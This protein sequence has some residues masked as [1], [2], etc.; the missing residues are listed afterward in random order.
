MSFHWYV[1][2][3]QVPGRSIALSVITALTL[4]I[5]ITAQAAPPQLNTQAPGYYR[6]ALGEFEITAL[7]D[8]SINI[9]PMLL[10]G[11]SEEDLQAL[12]ARMFA[13][14]NDG[15]QTAVNG[16]LV[17]TGSNLVLVDTGAAACFG[18]SLGR[19]HDNIRAA[20][21]ELKQVDTVLLTHLHA[22]HAC[23]LLDAEGNAAFSNAEVRV[24]EDEAGFWLSE[25][26]AAKAPKAMQSFFKM[27]R[28]S[29]AP[30][31]ENNRLK[32]YKIGDEL[33]PG[34]ETVSTP[35][36]TPGHVSYLFSSNDESLLIWGDIVHN[37]AVQFVYPEVSIEYDIDS[38]QA[39][40]TRKRIFAEAAL[41]KL[42]VAGAHL[43]FPGLGHVRAERQGY[44]WVPAEYRPLAPSN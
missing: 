42:W 19:M 17:H 1:L 15:I 44:L 40:A 8:G 13:D 41:D 3:R 39:I 18:P 26:A 11:V 36:H 24:S 32:T 22:D 12:L 2:A 7:Y 4:A 14:T 34:V 25:A 21:Y 5:A 33:L 10:E 37:Y 23:G 38:T 30:Y 9:D 29:V 35:G 43:P 27:S 28:D 16:Y 31:A 20:G 6:M